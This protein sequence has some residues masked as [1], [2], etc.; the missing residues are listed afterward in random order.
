ME[1]WNP[2]KFLVILEGLNC[3]ITVSLKSESEL[4]QS[5]HPSCQHAGSYLK[6]QGCFKSNQH[7]GLQVQQSR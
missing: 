5:G 7:R 1:S 6:S 4:E 2:I 3:V